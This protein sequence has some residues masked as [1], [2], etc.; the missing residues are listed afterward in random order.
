MSMPSLD[1]ASLRL[2]IDVAVV[3]LAW[4]LFRHERRP[5][6]AALDGRVGRLE[7]LRD[8]IRL[9]VTQAEGHAV[10]LDRRLESH[11][12]RIAGLL[13]T[14]GATRSPVRPGAAQDDDW[15]PGLAARSAVL[16]AES[17]SGPDP[18]AE[19]GPAERELR[20]ALDRARRGAA[21]RPS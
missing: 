20:R 1:S 6:L 16:R 13:A 15:Q 21:E 5:D 10:D 4:V 3:G 2:L 19:L 11:G 14:T 12:D 18:D 7:T 8:E 17:A 9:L